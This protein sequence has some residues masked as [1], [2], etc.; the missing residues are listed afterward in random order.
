MARREFFMTIVDST[1]LQESFTQSQSMSGIFDC[2]FHGPQY[3]R[4]RHGDHAEQPVRKKR[5]E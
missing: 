2:M 5:A 4:M 3:V 1:I